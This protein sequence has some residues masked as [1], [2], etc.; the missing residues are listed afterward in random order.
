MSLCDRAKR[1]QRNANWRLL[2]SL[3]QHLECPFSEYSHG[4]SAI[5]RSLTAADLADAVA[6]S[7]S[8]GW[9]QRTD[10][11]A[12]LM[13]HAPAGACGAFAGEQL[14]GT[15]I[16]LDYG[17]FGWIA[18]MLVNPEYRGQG[19]G[20]QLLEAAMRAIPD[21]RPIRLD[22][23]PMGRPLYQRYGFEDEER[24]TRHVAANAAHL[25]GAAASAT[26][27]LQAGDDTNIAAAD[28]IVFGGDRADVIAWMIE[29]GP[30]YAH[31]IEDEAG[32]RQYGLGRSG[33][34]FTQIGPIVA[35]EAAAA[36]S[37]VRAGAAAAGTNAVTVDAFD[38]HA[39]FTERLR[40]IGFEPQRPLYRMCRPGTDG[41]W[42]RP[43]SHAG[44]HEFAIL[45]PE[46][47]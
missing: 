13:R 4:M 47:A 28:R 38:C 32:S 17:S 20:K 31:A 24:L 37:L 45:G 2:Q 6:L 39:D 8:A 3:L 22:A 27:R 14:L 21:G 7:S 44:L 36:I 42:T 11:W 26:R 18:M 29:R 5:V 12:M 40:S 46:F 33:R 30:E 10:D 16:G 41:T 15:A 9:N 25:R 43:A 23:T 1:A 19:F 34:L 35:H